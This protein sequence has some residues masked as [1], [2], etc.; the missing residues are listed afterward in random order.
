MKDAGK[1]AYLAAKIGADTAENE[2][3]FAEHLQKKI[4]QNVLEALTGLTE[5]LVRALVHCRLEG[6]VGEQAAR[7]EGGAAEVHAEGADVDVRE[8][9]HV[10]DAAEQEADEPKE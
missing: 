7:R 2:Q 5:D 10:L 9:R 3:K 4:C 1:N 6:E 8:P